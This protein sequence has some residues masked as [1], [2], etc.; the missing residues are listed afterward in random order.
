M[1]AGRICPS[2]GSGAEGDAKFCWLCGYPLA[3]TAAAPTGQLV[4]APPL[5]GFVWIGGFVLALMVMLGV[6]LELAL[7]WPGLLVPYALM[8]VPVVA[9]MARIIYVQRFDFWRDRKPFESSGAPPSAQPANATARADQ[10]EESS[11]MAS[12]VMGEVATA[13]A[14]GLGAVVVVTGLVFLLAVAAFIILIA[15]CFGVLAF[16]GAY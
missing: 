4:A 11:S 1:K 6:A 8:L 16:G 14:I 5:E 9:V 15:I 2:C 12:D 13:L 10:A 3:E 7:L